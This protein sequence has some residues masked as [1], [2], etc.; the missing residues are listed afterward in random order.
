MLLVAY[1]ADARRRGACAR[2]GAE[3]QGRG[4]HGDL[5]RVRGRDAEGRDEREGR[6]GVRTKV[7]EKPSRQRGNEMFFR[8]KPSTRKPSGTERRNV[9]RSEDRSRRRDAAVDALGCGSARLPENAAGTTSSFAARCRV[10]AAK[11]KQTKRKRKR[12]VQRTSR[13]ATPV[14]TSSARWS[15]LARTSARDRARAARART[16]V[17]KTNRIPLRSPR[18]RASPVRAWS[19]TC[20]TAT[21]VCSTRTFSARRPPARARAGRAPRAGTSAGGGTPGASAARGGRGRRPR[22]ATSSSFLRDQYRRR[23]RRRVRR[24]RRRRRPRLR[25][26]LASRLARKAREDA[27]ERA[28]RSARSAE[29]LARARGAA[30]DAAPVPGVA[31]ESGEVRARVRRARPRSRL[32]PPPPEGGTVPASFA[33]AFR[34]GG[35]APRSERSKGK[36][37]AV[38]TAAANRA[39]PAGDGGV[40]PERVGV[41][42]GRVLRAEG[43]GALGR[44]P[45]ATSPAA[46]RPSRVPRGTMTPRG[47]GAVR[48]AALVSAGV[49]RFTDAREEGRGA[50]VRGARARRCAPRTR[51]R[52]GNGGWLRSSADAT[53]T[54]PP[55]VGGA[56]QRRRR[57][58]ERTMARTLASPLT[59]RR[60]R[61]PGL[62]SPPGGRPSRT[63]T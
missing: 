40:E 47:G 45:R 30:Q 43:R 38:R 3:H 9:G 57:A 44:T 53:T 29:A 15:R 31:P 16:T 18:R 11:K 61:R 2:Q 52:A 49:R 7:V 28:T 55:P 26:A 10:G 17:T 20:S 8:V 58:S 63:R 19:S 12:R 25:A 42:P 6:P 23:T 56:R 48:R 4:R 14:A 46:R 22:G 1:F 33:H 21:R 35:E 27:A 59:G 13:R 39:A 54:A 62:R 32:V 51:R 60:L 5:G 24:G 36:R 41:E 37:P 34:A 50:G